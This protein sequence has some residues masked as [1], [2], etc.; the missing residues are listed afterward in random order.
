MREQ[1][2]KLASLTLLT[3]QMGAGKTTMSNRLAS[4]Y[5]DVYH[6]DVGYV[7]KKTGTYVIPKG[8]EKRKA[9]A[10]KMRAILASHKAGR[11]VLLDGY[12]NSMTGDYAPLLPH[13]DKVLHLDHGPIR[14]N[15][16]VVRRS[17]ERGSSPWADLKYALGDRKA[18][19]A[20]L[21]QIKDAVGKDRVSVIDRSYRE[22]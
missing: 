13:V 7:D 8:E 11:R 3:G 2:I 5:D 9:I 19:N 10:A 17:F 20:S 4:D 21:Q 15:Y 1:L 12:P 16:A 18:T 14:S 22:G 6:S